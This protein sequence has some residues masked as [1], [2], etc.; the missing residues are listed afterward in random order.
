VK[1]PDGDLSGID[2]P[3]RDPALP[4]LGRMTGQVGAASA[5]VRALVQY[6]IVPLWLITNREVKDTAVRLYALL[7]AKY[8]DHGSHTC[9]P[10]RRT[11]AADLCVALSTIDVA[12]GQLKRASA[13]IVRQRRDP[14][15]DLTSSLYTLKID[16]PAVPTVDPLG[17]PKDRCALTDE[18][19]NRWTDCPVGGRP[20][21]RSENQNHGNHTHLNEKSTR[22]DGA[23]R[24][25]WPIFKGQRLVVFEWQMDDLTRMLGS[26]TNDFDLHMWFRTL[27]AYAVESACVIPQ[28]DGGAWVQGQTLVEARRRGLPVAIASPVPTRGKLTTRM[29]AL[30]ANA[31]EKEAG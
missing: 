5:V 6:G 24:S 30:V 16:P 21:N 10:S 19:V 9:Y 28:R 11:L 12:L 29:A 7:A 22:G 2:T 8:A 15:G 1:R 13:V 3:Y 4:Q 25:K 18:P 26:H 27:D 20:A 23:A 31:A 17:R 14:S